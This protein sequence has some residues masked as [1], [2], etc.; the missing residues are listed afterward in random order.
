[1][2]IPFSRR[3]KDAYVFFKEKLAIGFADFQLPAQPACEL[4]RFRQR[5]DA[6]AVFVVVMMAGAVTSRVFVMVV[7]GVM[8]EGNFLVGAALET[9]HRPTKAKG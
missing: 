4:Q 1:M 7:V 6:R 2:V 9:G 8:N 3:S 5:C